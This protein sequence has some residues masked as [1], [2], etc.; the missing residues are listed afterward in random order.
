MSF[1][2]VTR[3]LGIRIKIHGF[4]RVSLDAICYSK[5]VV[6]A[7]YILIVLNPCVYSGGCLTLAGSLRQEEYGRPRY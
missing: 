7:S 4:Q 3:S 2:Q 5:P 6:W 1:G